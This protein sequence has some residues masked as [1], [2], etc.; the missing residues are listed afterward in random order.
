MQECTGF[1]ESSAPIAQAAFPPPSISTELIPTV[2]N[3]WKAGGTVWV[4]KDREN[5]EQRS[6]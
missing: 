1:R 6:L 4:C 3:V 2:L 5:V